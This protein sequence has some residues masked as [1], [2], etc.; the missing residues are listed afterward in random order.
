VDDPPTVVSL[1]EAPQVRVPAA[2]QASGP[3]QAASREQS[4]SSQSTSP[5][6]SSSTP[7][8][9]SSDEMPMNSLIHEM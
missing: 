9:Q 4:G 1:M 7:F 6:E 5:S 2:S 3:W 8:W